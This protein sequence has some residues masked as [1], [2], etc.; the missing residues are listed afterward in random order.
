MGKCVGVWGEVWK[1]LGEMW[2]SVLGAE[3]GID[4]KKSKEII[5]IR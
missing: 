3:L 4:I 1:A 2:G 5:D